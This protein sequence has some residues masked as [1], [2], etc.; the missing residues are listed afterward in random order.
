MAAANVPCSTYER[1][2]QHP[3]PSAL[4]RCVEC[5]RLAEELLNQGDG[6]GPGIGY[7]SGLDGFPHPA[8]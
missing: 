3:V 5:E 2:T 6:S 4:K 7:Q 1:S 8:E